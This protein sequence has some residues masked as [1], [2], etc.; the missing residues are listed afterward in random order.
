[1]A[2]FLE[3]CIFTYGLLALIVK[4]FPTVPTKYPWLVDL[5]S[6]LGKI[7]NRQ[8]DDDAIRDKE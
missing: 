3:I 6:I 1:M 4:T 5:I 2:K 8:T 7:T